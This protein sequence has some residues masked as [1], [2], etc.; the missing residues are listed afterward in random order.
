MARTFT[1]DEA[2]AL[3]PRL[4]EILPEM[5][6]RKT[7]LDSLRVELTSM[8]R[9]ASGN[10]HLVAPDVDRKR[11]EAEGLAERLNELLDEINQLGCELKGIEEGLIDFRSPREERMVY[12]C[13]KLGEPEV[14]YWH[15]LDT[16]FASR[17]RL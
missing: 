5:Q 3:L 8:T 9:M 16:G 10:G 2:T 11:E 1:L 17:Q 7:A 12:L 13:W 6:E 15:E 4:S 14:V